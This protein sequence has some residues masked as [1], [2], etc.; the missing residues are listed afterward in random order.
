MRHGHYL[1]RRALVRR[2]GRRG[3]F[4]IKITDIR[5]GRTAYWNSRSCKANLFPLS[6]RTKEIGQMFIESRNPHY[7]ELLVITEN[8]QSSRPYFP[9]LDGVRAIAA[10]MVMAFHFCADKGVGGLALFGQ[11]GVDLFFVLSGFLITTILLQSPEKDW[12]EI[13]TF[14]IRRTLRIFPLYYGYLI[15]AAFLGSVSSVWY[16]IYL[17]NIPISMSVPMVGPGHFWSLAIEEQFYL[18]WPFLVLFLPRRWLTKTLW[19]IVALALISRMV[20]IPLN[21]SP[22]LFTLTRL[23]GLA[24]GALLAVYFQRRLINSHRRLLLLL[25]LLSAAALCGQWWKFHGQGLPW[26]QITKFTFTTCFYSS[27]VGYLVVSGPILANRFLRSGPMRFIGKISYGLYVFH[28]A[29]FSFLLLRMQRTPTWIQLMTCFA[30]TFAVSLC[31]WQLY[32]SRFVRLKDKFAPERKEFPA[33][34]A[35]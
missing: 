34:M 26:E 7:T 4:Q 11:T 23:D 13:R 28:P 22:F 29:I 20:L 32:E 5:K 9:E 14:Y 12:H 31:S 24:G 19:A 17:Q 21:V 10:L 33:A 1:R 3:R 2:R 27:V 16:W 18:V 30:A 6:A 35:A 25:A 8:S 15:L